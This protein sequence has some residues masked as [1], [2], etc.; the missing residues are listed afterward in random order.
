MSDIVDIDFLGV[1]PRVLAR[2]ELVDTL[3]VNK[4]TCLQR[5][6]TDG[7]SIVIDLGRGRQITIKVN[8]RVCGCGE[9]R[10]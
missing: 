8:Q 10:Q 5:Y 3:Q 6:R 1:R 7:D 4:D 2:G 9:V